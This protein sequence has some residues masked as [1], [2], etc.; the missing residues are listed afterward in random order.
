[1]A[2]AHRAGA[3]LG[4]TTARACVVQDHCPMVGRLEVDQLADHRADVGPEAK[5][6]ARLRA[7]S[8]T[9]AD[10]LH[11][12]VRLGVHRAHGVDHVLGADLDIDGR[13]VGDRDG[14]VRHAHRRQRLLVGEERLVRV[15]QRRRHEQHRR[16]PGR[17]E[18]GRAAQALRQAGRRHAERRTRLIDRGVGDRTGARGA[19]DPDCD[20]AGDTHDSQHE[21]VHDTPP[22]RSELIIAPRAWIPDRARMIHYQQRNNCATF[23]QM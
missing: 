6:P 19:S 2:R 21:L 9:P 20:R 4:G 17:S 5:R 3:A 12:P 23:M 14:A 10:D 11:P 7:A 8:L 22:I 15:G 13:V 1:M 16:T 18:T